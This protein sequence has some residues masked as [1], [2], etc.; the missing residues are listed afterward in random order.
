MIPYI[1]LLAIARQTVRRA[2]RS[3]LVFSLLFLAAL[4]VVVMPLILR[5]DGTLEGRYRILLMYTLNGS[6]ALLAMAALWSSCASV[7]TDAES[8]RLHLVLVK[9]VNAATLWFGQWLGLTVSYG[10]LLLLVWAAVLGQLYWRMPGAASAETGTT[11]RRASVIAPAAR[12]LTPEE[13]RAASHRDPQ[14]HY[15]LL[16]GRERT[17]SFRLPRGPFDDRHAVLEYSFSTSRARDTMERP[18]ISLALDIGE[19]SQASRERFSGLFH[20]GLRHRIEQIPLDKLPDSRL[21]VTLGNTS[22]DPPHT[23]LFH[24][25]DGLRL[26][27]P[28]G[29][30][31]RN[32]LR[33]AVVLLARLSFYIAVGLTAGTLFSF[34]VAAFVGGFWFVFAALAGYIRSVISL[35]VLV[36]PHEGPLGEPT[37]LDRS[38]IAVFRL[39]DLILQP[40]RNPEVITLLGSNTVIPAADM[41]VSLALLCLPYVGLTAAIGILALQRREFGD[42]A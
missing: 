24:R 9:P 28:E 14:N 11:G 18:L 16:P 4:I 41:A 6:H 37:V 23:L 1:P 5:D 30:H 33:A 8:R 27:I 13:D 31:A 39:F 35:G 40:L 42:V 21:Y 38:L 3:R 17:F 29:G 10:C 26:R 15:L 34:P 25:H 19:R 22:A 12:V 36:A 2:I 20:A 32:H 7:A